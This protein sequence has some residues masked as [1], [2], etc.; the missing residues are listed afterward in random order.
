MALSSGAASPIVSVIIPTYR[1][2]KFLR[3]CL[4]SVQE[5]DLPTFECIVVD[6]FSPEADQEI[7]SRFAAQDSRFRLIRHHSNK[8]VSEARNT[9][10]KGASG[11]FV[12]FLDADDK[13]LPGALS[14]PTALGLQHKADV[15][16]TVGELWFG[17]ARTRRQ[18]NSVPSFTPAT[19]IHDN[20][21]LRHTS[22][23]KSLLIRRQVLRHNQILFDRELV[24][25]EDIEFMSRAL[26]ACK[27][28][29]V[30]PLV[31]YLYR[32]G[33]ESL[34]TRSSF[35]EQQWRSFGEYQRKV[36][37]NYDGQQKLRTYFA[38]EHLEY[39]IMNLARLQ[40]ELG[41]NPVKEVIS[42]IAAPY[43]GIKTELFHHTAEQPCDV[44]LEYEPFL[45]RPF[46]ALSL[47]RIGDVSRE[48]A[49]LSTGPYR[50]ELLELAE[51]RNAGDCDREEKVTIS[52]FEAEPSHPEFALEYGTW[53]L[54]RKTKKAL[55]ILL[56]ANS[57]SARIVR[58]TLA[59][60]TALRQNGYIE[61]APKV[62]KN[63]L[64]KMPCSPQLYDR[65][66]DTYAFCGQVEERLNALRQACSHAPRDLSRRERLIEGLMAASLENEALVEIASVEKTAGSAWSEHLLSK[67][68]Q[69]K[70]RSERAL[71][72]I[73]TLLNE[74]AGLDPVAARVLA[75]ALLAAGEDARAVPHLEMAGE[76]ESGTKYRLKLAEVERNLG[77]PHRA[78][79]VLTE[80]FGSLEETRSLPPPAVV[81]ATFDLLIE[82]PELGDLVTFVR[83]HANML[84][85]VPAACIHIWRTAKAT[86]DNAELL[87]AAGDLLT[88]AIEEHPAVLPLLRARIDWLLSNR[89]VDSALHYARLLVA[90][91][92]RVAAAHADLGRC[93][94]KAGEYRKAAHAYQAAHHLRPQSDEFARS[95]E[96]LSRKA[97]TDR[98]GQ[99]GDA[100][101]RTASS[102]TKP[103]L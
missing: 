99:F 86:R 59:L 30:S 21:W 85:G 47:S 43:R 92:P 7:A 58:S 54:R 39:N 51:A 14:V 16:R 72:S 66:A 82:H 55:D 78:L 38:L 10:L 41:P 84:S 22:Q 27:R 60:C 98:A 95:A 68:E 36:A 57:H 88:A 17:R 48:V 33:H 80:I 52:I 2:E 103:L 81:I 26:L 49:E 9:G 44:P 69:R 63:A 45:Y 77:R 65:L 76:H 34:T 35:S 15:V 50:R 18:V 101:Q 5:Q 1:S 87:G 31:T 19:N 102:G 93:L 46:R 97:G 56:Y 83:D 24:L 4:T 11:E 8:G 91:Y 53:L 23:L 20:Q 89:K 40:S 32:R 73:D 96:R 12:L 28:A 3:E 29:C 13:L 70:T 67:V 100:S 79:S 42:N 6:D 90:D 71:Q 64:R 74:N 37:R 94:A 61:Q 75:D 25:G 62:I